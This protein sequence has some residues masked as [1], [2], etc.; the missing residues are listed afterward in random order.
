MPFHLSRSGL[1]DRHLTAVLRAI[2]IHEMTL[3]STHQPVADFLDLGY[4]Q[5]IVQM[6]H[7]S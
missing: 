2:H 4:W 1:A 7:H 6:G 3:G 5:V